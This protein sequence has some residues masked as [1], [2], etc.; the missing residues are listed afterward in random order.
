MIF[1]IFLI[2]AVLILFG[3]SIYLHMKVLDLEKLLS[4]T[5]NIVSNHLNSE[6]FV[7]KKD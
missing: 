4:I 5:S 2:I 1:N 6:T 7:N 3:I